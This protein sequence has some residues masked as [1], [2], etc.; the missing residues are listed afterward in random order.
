MEILKYDSNG[1]PLYWIITDNTDRWYLKVVKRLSDGSS[2][3]CSNYP[4]CISKKVLKIR[5][6][7]IEGN[8]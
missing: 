1:M 4:E 2:Q 7:L 6:S 3:I 5:Q 8:F